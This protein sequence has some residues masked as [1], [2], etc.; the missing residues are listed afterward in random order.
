MRPASYAHYPP[1]R[2]GDRPSDG[3]DSPR[4]PGAHPPNDSLQPRSI[5]RKPNPLQASYPS[6]PAFQQPPR[7][8]RPLPTTPRVDMYPPYQPPNSLYSAYN[9]SPHSPATPYS[10]GQ[11]PWMP[12]GFES[13]Q[14]QYNPSHHAN[15]PQTPRDHGDFQKRT[16]LP[17]HAFQ[18]QQNGARDCF[19]SMPDIR[20]IP[21]SSSADIERDRQARACGLQL[22]YTS[23]QNALPPS[24]Q[25]LPRG[26][27]RPEEDQHHR[28]PKTQDRGKPYAPRPKPHVL[29]PRL[30]KLVRREKHRAMDHVSFDEDVLELYREEGDLR[31]KLREKRKGKVEKRDPKF[32]V[33]GAPLRDILIHAS[34]TIT[35]GEHQHDVPTLVVACVEELTRTGIYQQGLFRTLP[36]RDRHIQLIDIYDSSADYGEKFSMHGQTMPDIC[37]VLSTFISCLPHPLLDP[38]LYGGFWHWCVKP[39]VKREEVRRSQQDAEEEEKRTRGELPLLLPMS[40]KQHQRQAQDDLH[41]G[42]DGDIE[43]HQIMVAQIILR[44]LPVGQ[45][46]L[47]IYLCGFF[48]QL[49][50]CPENGIQFEDIAR[51]FGHKIFGATAKVSSQ[52]MMVWLLSRWHNISEGLLTDAC[53]MSR[54]S[55]PTPKEE[56]LPNGEDNGDNPL[57]K[58]PSSR[59]SRSSDSDR[60]SYSSSPHDRAESSTTR[61]RKKRSIESTPESGEEAPPRSRRPSRRNQPGRRNSAFSS[62]RR[63]VSVGDLPDVFSKAFA[64]ARVSP[65]SSDSKFPERTLGDPPETILLDAQVRLARLESDLRRNNMVVVD[66]IK[67]TFKATDEARL[68]SEKVEQLER[69][70]RERKPHNP[71]TPASVREPLQVSILEA[72]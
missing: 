64:N 68:L 37:A 30:D 65:S 44:F 27:R 9:D 48:T 16:S 5:L 59:R 26:S 54:P 14:Q 2:L 56:E 6:E 69:T 35:I 18:Q 45:L 25:N 28:E 15:Y 46:S 71:S 58:T 19:A 62:H 51:I 72:K 3:N 20:R 49:P 66:A 47:L 4:T 50:L 32:H 10:R 67:E 21:R 55:T 36:S 13:R 39:S 57:L 29:Y 70:F 61:H 8:S 42:H 24:F 60:S 31:E 22:D 11:A 12:R 63:K 43:R 52:K 41:I 7:L 33:I 17:P 40:A 1:S 38:K 34:S 53:G 23:H